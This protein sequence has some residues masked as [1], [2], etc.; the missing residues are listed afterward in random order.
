[1]QQHQEHPLGPGADTRSGSTI[2]LDR[3]Y[4]LI[5]SPPTPDTQAF[6]NEMQRRAAQWWAAMDAPKDNSTA[7]DPDT[8]YELDCEPVGLPPPINFP[9][10]AGAR[11]LPG[12]VSMVCRNDVFWRG[13]A[14]GAYGFG[15]Y[16]GFNW[17]LHQGREVLASDIFDM[18]TGWLRALTTATN[19]DRSAGASGVVEPLDFSDTSHWVVTSGGLGLTYSASDFNGIEEG[20]DG[21]YVV[22]P[23]SKL[24]PYLR[25]DGIVPQADW[26]ATAM[27]GN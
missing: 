18:K 25:K 2:H 21:K 22:I 4:P 8:D 10:P 5:A 3:T 17:L 12:L 15:E 11:M 23:W 26:S 7:A 1:M 13:A 24:A 14:H 6:N 20:G 27:P 9:P 19:L 16:W